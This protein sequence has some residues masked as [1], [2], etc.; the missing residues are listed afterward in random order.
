MN[1]FRIPFAFL[2]L[3]SLLVGAPG[4]AS[5]SISE[6]ASLEAR[7]NKP[8]SAYSPTSRMLGVKR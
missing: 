1:T 4:F 8:V 5:E 3:F 7:L 2:S 6:E